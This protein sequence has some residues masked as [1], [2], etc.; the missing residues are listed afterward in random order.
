M[1]IIKYD[2]KIKEDLITIE[3]DTIIYY[4]NTDAKISIKI[5]KN[6]RIC[7]LFI[8]S[9]ISNTY[10]IYKEA[11]IERFNI[12]SSINTDINLN[13]EYASVDY[14]Y[15]CLNT[16]TNSYNIN[17]NHNSSNTKGKIINRG[18]NLKNERL[19]FVINSIIPKDK[20]NCSSNQ[21]SIIIVMEDNNC[22]IKPNLIVDNY[23]VS[24]SH[25][26]YI[27]KFNEEKIFYLNTRGISRKNALKIM[28]KA[29]LIS[30]RTFSLDIKNK[31]L[32]KINDYWR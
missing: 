6:V 10:D 21:D 7:E 32:E 15:S 13:H 12:N 8:D 16:D 26:A 30:D 28:A 29:F 25:S 20:Y 5:N 23:D 3:E 4:L 22:S 18:I 24:A 14:F 11:V 17:I 19:D 27:G 2:S 31:V 9:I 1:N